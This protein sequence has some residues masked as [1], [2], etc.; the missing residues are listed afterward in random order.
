MK[1][2]IQ[3]GKTV[4]VAAPY[5][6]A[7][8]AGCLVGSLF[9]VATMDAASGASV[10]IT[11]CGVYT[12]A[13]T[14]AQAWTVGAK[15]YWDDTNKVVTTTATSNTLIGCALEA[16]ANPSATGTVRLNGTV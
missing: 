13:K 7:S 14:S 4:T 8:G 16:A 10:D 6:V 3:P 11:T 12:L 5:D 1:T 15:V 2:F 9:G